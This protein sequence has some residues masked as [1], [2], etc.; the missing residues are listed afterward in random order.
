M[1]GV[2]VAHVRSWEIRG[3]MGRKA[4]SILRI[5]DYSELFNKKNTE[6]DGKRRKCTYLVVETR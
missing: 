2:A 1:Q 5:K 4:L 3:T 6:G